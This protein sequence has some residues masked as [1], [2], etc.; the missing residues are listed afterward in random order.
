MTEARYVH[1]LRAC[2]DQGGG[3]QGAAVRR[4]PRYL[5]PRRGP[6][7]AADTPAHAPSPSPTPMAYRHRRAALEPARIHPSD[8]K[9]DGACASENPGQ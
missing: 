3:L 5:M 7:P 1:C 6:G 4:S 8:E 2:L 9:E